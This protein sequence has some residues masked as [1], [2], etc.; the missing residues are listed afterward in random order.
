MTPRARRAVWAVAVLGL[1]GAI[2]AFAPVT[3]PREDGSGVPPPLRAA[4]MRPVGDIRA[5]RSATQEFVA[6]GT[7]IHALSL[8]FGTY[9]R[10]NHGTALVTV[11]ARADGQWREVGAHTI[12]ISTLRDNAYYTIT[13]APQLP[14]TKGEPVRVTLSSDGG[15]GDAITWWSILGWQPAGST[16]TYNGRPLA[17]TA[18]LRVSYAVESGPLAALALPVWRRMTI[19]LDPLWQMALALSL[20]LIA[21]GGVALARSVGGTAPGADSGDAHG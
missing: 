4:L 9:L 2:A 7:R 17:A 13:F 14:V 16:L 8:L 15:A 12:D 19:F 1:V 3:L 18:Y 6:T 11:H 5:G 10:T 21:A 20:G